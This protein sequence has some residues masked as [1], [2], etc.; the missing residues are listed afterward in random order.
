MIDIKT[1]VEIAKIRAGGERLAAIMEKIKE[2]VKPGVTTQELDDLAEKLATQHQAKPSFRDYNGFPAGLC[3]SVNE[4]LV[5][6]LPSSREI[7]EGD[8]VGLDFGL[9][10]QGFYTDMAVTIGVGKVSPE[11]QK[12]MS[13]TAES[14]Q[15]GIDQIK[16]GNHIGDIS[17]AIQRHAESHNYGVVR[18]L[19]GHGVGRKVHEPPQI[20]DFGN[21]G[22]GPELE[23]GMVL[24]IEPMLSLGGH[25]TKL[26]ADGWTFKMKDNS[27]S[28]HFEHTVV[29][30]E[31]G[32]EILTD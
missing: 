3:V 26:A 9:L 5:H 29:V 6:G 23:A 19:T 17:A 16:P 8:I 13:V 32:Y 10:Y 1:E 2:A 30:T 4:E 14:L 24:A 12:L 11:A 15:L 31:D 21:P 27:L 20:P 7:K 25:E 28:A 22:D 18:N